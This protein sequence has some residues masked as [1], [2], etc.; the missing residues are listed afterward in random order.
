[1]GV[2]TASLYL[3][4]IQE[5]EVERKVAYLLISVA[6]G[7]V[8]GVNVCSGLV[9]NRYDIISEDEER[10]RGQHLIRASSD[11]AESRPRNINSFKWNNT[12]Q[13]N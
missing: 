1:M 12:I 11:L 8:N 10:E 2:I 3:T 13:G 4:S 9:W 6:Q 7:C 5:S